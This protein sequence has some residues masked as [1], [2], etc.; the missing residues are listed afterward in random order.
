MD[1]ESPIE[2]EESSKSIRNTFKA[3]FGNVKKYTSIV[4]VVL[5]FRVPDNLCQFAAQ[6]ATMIID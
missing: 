2:P 4:V 3:T 1:P 6:E 5:P